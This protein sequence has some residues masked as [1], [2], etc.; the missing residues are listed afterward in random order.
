MSVSLLISMQR[1]AFYKETVVVRFIYACSSRWTRTFLPV[2]RLILTLARYL[3]SAD[4]STLIG[5]D[6]LTDEG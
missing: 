1:L 5:N 3:I 4:K 6:F 2:K